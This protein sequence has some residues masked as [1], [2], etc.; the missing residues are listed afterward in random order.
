DDA[1][2][3][4]QRLKDLETIARSHRL[5]RLMVGAGLLLGLI[6]YVSSAVKTDPKTIVLVAG[7]AAVLNELLGLINERA[8]R[9]WWFVYALSLLDVLLLAVLIVWF[10][11]GGLVAAFFIAVLPY[12]FDQGHAVGDLLVLISALAY[13]AAGQWHYRLYG[14]DPGFGTAS[15]LETVVFFAV[16]MGLKRIPPAL[17]DRIREARSIMGEAGRGYQI[18]RAH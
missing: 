18:G 13:L 16:A 8:R 17:I 4:E 11:H 7:G 1:T 6:G 2:G 5:R 9:R 14:G 12:A 15:Y 10:G 3:L